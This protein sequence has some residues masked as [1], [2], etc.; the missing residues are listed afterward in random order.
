MCVSNTVADGSDE[1][2]NEPL[3][4]V[5]PPQKKNSSVV[6]QEPFKQLINFRLLGT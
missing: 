3:M 6:L 5:R 4:S 1:L 2:M